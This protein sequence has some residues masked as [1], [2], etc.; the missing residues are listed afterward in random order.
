MTLAALCACQAKE[1]GS[2]SGPDSGPATREQGVQFSALELD[3]ILSM[4]PLPPPPDDPTNSVH[5]NAH[6]AR[7]GQQLFFDTR[8]SKSRSTAC[9]SCHDPELAW[10]DGKA[11]SEGVITLNRHAPSLLNV[12][13]NRWLFWDGRADSLWAQALTPLEHPL[14]H[15]SSRLQIAHTIHDD[16]DLRGAYEEIFGPM[17]D[18]GD[19]ERFPAIGRPVSETE[20]AWIED[21]ARSKQDAGLAPEHRHRAGA[22]FIHP[23]QRAWDA[24]QEADQERVTRIFVNLGKSIAAFERQLVAS[25]SEFDSFVE[26]LRTGDPDKLAA[27][28]ISAQ[29]GLQLF[30]GRARCHICHQGPTLSDRE[31][32]DIGI[33]P[34]GAVR[35]T[36][37]G[38][39]EGLKQVKEDP[40]NGMGQWSDDPEGL[41]RERIA[42]LPNHAHGSGA[43]FK[44]PSLRNVAVTAPYM[45]QGQMPTLSSVL[46]HYSNVSDTPERVLTPLHLSEQEH[47]DLIH[48]LESLTDTSVDSRLTVPPSP[49]RHQ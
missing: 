36:D 6:A 47:D 18:L 42:F 9:S 33:P 1:T 3:R 14:E 10:A 23:H 24:M 32:H 34:S 39:R 15:A 48:F 20:M 29:R 46:E 19:R 22:H 8:L 28:D 49:S 25:A 31:F 5:A 45:H 7:L 17:P 38:R 44:T 35:M 21:L 11:L 43:E 41:G 4:S 2:V 13:H 30:V 12:A 27:L 37:L 16:P 40:F 26:G